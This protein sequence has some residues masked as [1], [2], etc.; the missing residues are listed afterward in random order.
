MGNDFYGAIGDVF[1]TFAM[2]NPD[3][4]SEVTLLKEMAPN[5]PEDLIKRL[6]GAFGDLRKAFDDG[7]ASY[8]YS[9]RV[10]NF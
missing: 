8:P 10:L 9:L 1:G 2:E 4:E 3:F 5:V 7:V 6:V